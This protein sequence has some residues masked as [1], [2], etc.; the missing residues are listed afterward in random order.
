MSIRKIT[1][2]LLFLLLA[3][4][5]LAACGGGESPAEEVEEAAQEVEAEVEEAVEETA[6]EVEEAVEEVEEAVEEEVEEAVEE[7][8]KLL[9][10]LKKQLRKLKKPLKKKWVSISV[11]LK[12]PF[13]HVWGRGNPPKAMTAI[14]DDF[15][16]SN[17]WG[18]TVEP[19]RPGPPG[20]SGRSCQRGNSLWRSA[21]CYPRLCQCHGKLELCRR[22]QTHSTNSYRRP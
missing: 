17:E 20:R 15:N 4:F 13:W 21:Q 11:V 8:K 19:Y 3:V 10:R 5:L 18:I 2:T 16:N 14:V 22:H 9:K 6:E 1:I 7:L 12:F